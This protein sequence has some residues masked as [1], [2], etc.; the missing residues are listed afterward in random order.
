MQST[1]NQTALH[2]VAAGIEAGEAQQKV[3]ARLLAAK[4]GLIDAVDV[5]GWTVLHDACNSSSASLAGMFLAIK[6]ELAFVINNAGN[7]PLIFAAG[8]MK[9]EAVLKRLV[10]LNPA[11]VRSRNC[12]PFYT[13]VEHHND[14][15]IEI[16][17]SHLTFGEI[18]DAFFV[19]EQ[20]LER[21]RP[22][23]ASQCESLV[24]WLNQ[25]VVG[26]VFDYLSFNNKK[27]DASASP[28]KKQKSYC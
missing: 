3:A 21:Y 25:D 1:T 13:A 18:T 8:E 24:V 22:V 28:L 14:I 5:G 6:P 27:K 11:A 4:P 20:S 16:M 9:N 17:Q 12:F 15:A 26:I 10:E 19:A 7:S 2:L 23:V